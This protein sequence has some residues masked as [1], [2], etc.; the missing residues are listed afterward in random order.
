ME[1][2]L[3]QHFPLLGGFAG[4]GATAFW[5]DQITDDSLEAAPYLEHSMLARWA[6]GRT[7]R[8]LGKLG[9]CE[10]VSEVKWLPELETRNRLEGDYL[11]M[12]LVLKF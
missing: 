11:W 8:G 10:V 3:A 1:G 12:K 2:V 6:S 4:V 7:F 9:P 5:Y